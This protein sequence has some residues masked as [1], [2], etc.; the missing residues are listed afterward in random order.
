VDLGADLTAQRVVHQ[1]M[2]GQATHSSEALGS[3]PHAKV[4]G[5]V[6]RA[7]VAAVEMALVDH[8][9]LARR[10]RRAQQGLDAGA[11]IHAASMR[12]VRR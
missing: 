3:H 1:T 2:A 8:L 10:E 7:G 9:E 5:A 6:R 4:T 11:P 12:R